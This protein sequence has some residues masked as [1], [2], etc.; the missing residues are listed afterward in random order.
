MKNRKKFLKYF[1]VFILVFSFVSVSYC[2]AAESIVQNPENPGD[3]CPAGKNCGNYTLNEFVGIFIKVANIF[4]QISGSLALGAFVVGGVM[5]I[6][7]GGNKEN[8]QK[9][10]Q[11][12]LAAVVGLVIIFSSY[13]IIQFTM[14]ALGVPWTGGFLS[15]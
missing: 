4:L 6:I 15:I 7:S 14:K 8:V 5:M 9:G 11:I 13:L 12:L 1:L 2:L 10:K 3:N